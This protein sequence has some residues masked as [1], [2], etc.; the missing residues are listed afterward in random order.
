MNRTLT[1]SAGSAIFVLAV[2]LAS[3]S[4]VKPTPED[5]IFEDDATQLQ[6]RSVQSRVYDVTDRIR[7]MRAV[8]ATLLDL[9][10]VIDEA[11]SD[12]GVIT[13]TRMSGYLLSATVLVTDKDDAHLQVRARMQTG[14]TPLAE[15]AVREVHMSDTVPDD[16]YQEFFY[17]L[18]QN[19]FLTSLWSPLPER[20]A[21]SSTAGEGG[22]P[23]KEMR[24]D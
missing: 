2:L 22:K 7:L 24:E 18:R 3:C 14:W 8:I 5:A 19:L 16:T 20:S 6:I 11:D 9:D 21:A 1:I 15:T 4:A 12:M 10:F 17:S 23:Q 13:A